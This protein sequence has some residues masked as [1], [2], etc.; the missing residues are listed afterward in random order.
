M[1]FILDL[2]LWL[3]WVVVALCGGSIVLC[4]IIF[5]IAALRGEL[6]DESTPA[7]LLERWSAASQPPGAATPKDA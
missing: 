5:G 3:A 7:G 2:I 4:W 1:I 6:T